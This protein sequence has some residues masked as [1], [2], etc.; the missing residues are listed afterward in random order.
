[1]AWQTIHDPGT[2]EIWQL[3]FALAGGKERKFGRPLFIAS[4]DEICEGKWIRVDAPK[5]GSFKF[6]D[7]RNKYEKTY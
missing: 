7:S 3:H 2:P 5:D 1:M 6:Y 4:V